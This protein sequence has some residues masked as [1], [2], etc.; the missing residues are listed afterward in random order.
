MTLACSKNKNFEKVAFNDFSPVSVEDL[1]ELDV[2]LIDL[3][4]ICYLPI[5]V[6]LLYKITLIDPQIGSYNPEL[7]SEVSCLS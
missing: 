6:I 5:L 7:T 4:N 2:Q 1:S 3:T